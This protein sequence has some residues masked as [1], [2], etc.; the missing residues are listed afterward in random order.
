VLRKSGWVIL[1]YLN[2]RPCE[3][4]LLIASGKGKWEETRTK[5]VPR[6]GSL[7]SA[8]LPSVEQT[9]ST[10]E[11]RPGSLRSSHRAA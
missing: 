4:R 6:P 9:H 2:I 7:L 1:I 3:L 10:Q 11:H 8:H 5:K